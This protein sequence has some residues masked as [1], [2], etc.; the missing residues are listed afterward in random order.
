MKIFWILDMKF[1]KGNR[2]GEELA[3]VLVPVHGGDRLM[4]VRPL[5]YTE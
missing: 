1:L 4:L 5:S 2:D 3:A